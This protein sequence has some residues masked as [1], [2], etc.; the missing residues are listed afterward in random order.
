MKGL[1]MLLT[2]LL[3]LV[4]GAILVLAGKLYQARKSVR[5][6]NEALEDIRN[7]NLNRR[8]LAAPDNILAPFFY[9][10]NDIME[11]YRDTIAELNERDQANRQMMTSLSH[12]VRT[13]LTT[14]IG[15]LD[16]VH[17][18]LVE[19]GEREAYI[20]TAREKAHSLQMYV[21]DLFEWFKLNSNER[22]LEIAPVNVTEMTQTVLS[23]WLPVFEQN[24]IDYAFF[25]P[26]KC[27]TVS[28]DTAAYRRIL[29]NLIQNV[30]SH[31]SASAISV[32]VEEKK[33]CVEIWVK[34]NGRGIP[35]RELDHIFD[36]LYKCDP[37][38][39]GKG[40]GLGLSIVEQLVRLQN[41]GIRVTSEVGKG[42][43]FLLDFKPV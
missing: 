21:D 26:E 8:I 17:S 12:D 25:I 5:D 3:F 32:G 16:A 6:M 7:G 33:D 13:P 22:V 38:R 11:G 14:L 1:E 30:V 20:E 36:R 27:I 39:M 31:S 35:A 24:K 15:Y 29:N 23:D 2:A 37:A 4:G 43:S 9:K 42:T 10:I 41:G 18:H 40:S 34:D 28:L 19:G